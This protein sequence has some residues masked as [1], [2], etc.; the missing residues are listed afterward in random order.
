MSIFQL[1]ML[2]LLPLDGCRMQLNGCRG[3]QCLSYFLTGLEVLTH[4]KTSRPKINSNCCF[5]FGHHHREINQV[6]ENLCSFLSHLGNTGLWLRLPL[7]PLGVAAGRET[8]SSATQVAAT[9]AASRPKP[10]PSEILKSTNC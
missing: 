5:E 6:P 9:L 8:G 3:Y 2:D 7:S 1:Y 4:E 10:M